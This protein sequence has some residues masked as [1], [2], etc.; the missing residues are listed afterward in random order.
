MRAS[1]RRR[2]T[3]R[4]IVRGLERAR[5][6]A[7]SNA[8][9]VAPRELVPGPGADLTRHV[10]EQ[11]FSVHHAAGTCRMGADGGAVVDGQLRVRGVDGL[12]VVDCSVMPRVVGG[13]T[14]APTVMIAERAAAW[15]DG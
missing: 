8:F 10:V 3:F 15:I 6:I 14:N 13:N 12:R 4:T 9:G 1:C 5:E 7:H 11:S 2:P